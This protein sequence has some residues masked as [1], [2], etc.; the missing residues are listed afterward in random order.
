FSPPELASSISALVRLRSFCSP[1]GAVLGCDFYGTAASTSTPSST[2]ES[3][4]A[5]AL[6][7]T[8]GITRASNT[9]AE[10]LDVLA[11]AVDE[12]IEKFQWQELTTVLNAL[13]LVSSSAGSAAGG[14]MNANGQILLGGSGTT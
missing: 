3:T 1:G 7:S 12:K 4:S 13:S 8:S 5:G 9:T 10:A 6:A 14:A 2:S 11:T